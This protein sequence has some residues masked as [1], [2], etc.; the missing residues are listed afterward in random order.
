MLEPLLGRLDDDAQ[1][2]VERK[3]LLLAAHGRELGAVEDRPGLARLALREDA[4]ADALAHRD[5]HEVE[6]GGEEEEDALRELPHDC[7]RARGRRVSDLAL[8]E[9]GGNDETHESRREGRRRRTPRGGRTSRP[10]RTR[11]VAGSRQLQGEHSIVRTRCEREARESCR[12]APL[13][14][15]EKASRS[16]AL[17]PLPAG[18]SYSNLDAPSSLI[19]ERPT[20]AMSSL[21]LQPRPWYSAGKR[22]GPTRV[23]AE[24]AGRMRLEEGRAAENR[25]DWAGDRARNVQRVRATRIMPTRRNKTCEGESQTVALAA[26]R[27]EEQR[28]CRRST[29]GN[30][31]PSRPTR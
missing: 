19:L 29:F 24:A 11:A 12:D 16:N 21:E 4:L 20:A 15:K 28:T 9:Q 18:G 26:V 23:G 14:E 7:G 3:R 1:L 17:G 8:D 6:R 27:G 13:N 2:V 30:L 25:R 5:A 22:R 10:A 31:G